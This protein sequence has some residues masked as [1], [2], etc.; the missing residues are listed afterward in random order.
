MIKEKQLLTYSCFSL[1][2]LTRSKMMRTINL[3]SN[4]LH[5]PLAD[6]LRPKNLTQLVGQQELLE[7]G[8]P[9][10]QIIDGKISIS[11]II[12]G[13]PGTGK[14][15]LAKVIAETQSLPFETFNASIDKKEKLQQLVDKHPQETF[16]LQLDEIHRL[17]KPIQDFLL[18]HLENG[19]I[20]MIGTTTENPAITINPAL[21]SRC[22]I[23]EFKRLTLEN[24]TKLVQKAWTDFY[25]Y[26]K[27]ED[28]YAQLISNYAGG[29]GRIAINMV[30]T[31]QAMYGNEL[32]I[33]R[34]KLFAAN[35]NI[36][37][38]KDSNNHYD[39]LSAFQDSL[40]GSDTDAALYYLS[41]ILN[42]GDLESAVRRIRDAAYLVVGLAD[43]RTVDTAILAC[44]TA[45]QIG[46][47]R[48]STPLSYAVINIC[49]APKSDSVR[50]AY[51][52]AIKDGKNS[53]R[54]PMPD[55]LRD[56][57]YKHAAETTGG[58][59]DLIDP[60]SQPYSVAVQQYLP[61]KLIDRKYWQPRNTERERE[62]YS[63]YTRIH[64]F[65]KKTRKDLS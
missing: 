1:I 64:K 24:V 55:Y 37:F 21:R 28:S 49:L 5:Q 60:F 48:A 26:E 27:L 3:F 52:S 62:L 30:E 32:S 25:H 40:E 46:L 42:A 51:A 10:R 19:Q 15:S 2:N 4:Q 12:W 59:K 31:L 9:L 50:W 36:N 14:T 63:R 43:P 56:Y 38:D 45:L 20:L 16:I 54:Y 23:F 35:Q 17:T 8:K 65:V 41:V 29:D 58:G 18:P 13:P 7:D 6:V 44:Q 33:E 61:K 57:H 47:P 39:Y 53:P 22:Q 34:I 11:I